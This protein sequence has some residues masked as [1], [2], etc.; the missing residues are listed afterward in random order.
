MGNL[1]IA[2]GL[3]WALLPVLLAAS[4]LFFAACSRDSTAESPMEILR[5]AE[6]A[7]GRLSSYR[8]TMDVWQSAQVAG[9][10]DYRS[11]TEIT[12]VSGKGTHIATR[13]EG[14]GYSGYSESLLL[15]GTW[16]LRNGPDE[17]WQS[18]SSNDDSGEVAMLEYQEDTSPANNL[19]DAR[20]LGEERVNGILTTKIRGNVNMQAKVER[21][22][23]DSQSQSTEFQAS[24]D[25]DPRKQHLAGSE[26]VTGWVGVEDNLLHALETRGSFPASGELLAYEYRIRVEFF[27]FNEPLELPTP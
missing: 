3:M 23:G 20:V 12:V 27:D 8:Y 1:T 26:V 19:I 2:K 5:Q 18:L 13:V 24:H 10:S 9:E 7:T 21:I 14:S 4:G 17:A 16:Y 15:D 22:W 6:S 25:E 11:F